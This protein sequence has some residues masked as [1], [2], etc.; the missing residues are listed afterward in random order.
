METLELMEVILGQPVWNQRV[1][2]LMSLRGILLR[3]LE[4]DS[5]VRTDIVNVD[6]HPSGIVKVAGIVNVADTGNT[7]IQTAMAG[8]GKVDTGI[9]EVVVNSSM[10]RQIGEVVRR[11]RAL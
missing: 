5:V 4:G 10:M 9:V 6:I 1:V 3:A 7:G 11:N 2:A 8:T